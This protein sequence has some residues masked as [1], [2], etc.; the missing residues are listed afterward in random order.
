MDAIKPLPQVSSFSAS[1]FSFLDDRFRD[2][3]DLSQSPALVSELETEIFELD[4][5]LAGLNRQLES[6]LASYASFSD[7]I[8]GLL[9]GVN[10]KLA[11]L[12]SSRSASDGGKGEEETREHVA[13]EEL[14]SLAKEVAQV[15]SVRAYAETALKLDTLVGDI[16]DAVMSSLN[17]NLPTSRSSG[18]EEVRLHAIKTLQ[19]TEEIL[20]LVAKRHPRWGRLVSAVD[21]RVDRALAMLRPQAIADYRALLTS[22][23]WP[24]QLSNLTSSSLDSKSDD[25]QNPLFNMEGNLKSQYCGNFH[26]LCSLQGLQL[27]RKSR[28]LGSHKGEN[29]LFHQPLWAIEEL[30]NPLTVASQR[31][32][33]KW[34]EK[35][36]FIFALVYKITRDYV[37]SMD[38]LL[39][40]LV[41]KAKLAGYSCREEWVSAMVSSLSLYLV[42]EIFPTYVGQLNEP[43]LSSEAKVSWLHLIDLMIS[44]DKRAQ[45]LVSQSG[46]LSL[47][48]D[49][50]LLR[51][52]SLSVFCDRPDW[53]DIWAEIELDERL[54]KLKA[55][56]DNDRNWTVKV[57]DELISTSNVYRPPIVSSILLQHLSSIIERSKSVPAIYLRASFLRLAASSTIQKFLDCLLLRC[58]EA[59]GLTALTENN[60]LIKVSNSINAGHYIESVLDEWCEDVFFLEM[61]SGQDN[62]QEAPGQENFTEPSEGIFGEEFEKLEK[63]RL[64]WIN[65]LSVVVFRGLDARTREYIKNRK[66]WQEKRDK[67]WTVSRALVGALD[68]LQGK[69]SIIQENLNKADFTAMW[70][71]LASEIDKLF[72]N[73]ILMANVKFSDDG[74]ERFRED[75]EVLYGVF[76]GWCVR[77]EGFFPKL[78][79]GLTL[80][81]MKEKQ[82]KEGLSR[83]EKWLRE[84]GVRYMTEAEAKRIAKSRVFS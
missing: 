68:Y 36:E 40:P 78:S 64:E 14:P 13:G 50:N 1:V 9:I 39:Q 20:S 10:A 41:D 58:Q 17:K 60:D 7:R 12:S 54:V 32:F 73:S 65:K 46:I 33:A 26:A 18:F 52:S 47:Q 8:G 79:E 4:Q 5:R 77:P 25:I 21:H 3:A 83:G 49:G 84:N 31:H 82:V 38:E 74:V 23:G 42:K 61:G 80:L 43:D 56:M 55:E 19:K 37:D 28:Q 57:Q 44:F 24:P 51:I 72:F 29:V 16:E 69:T 22:L 59:E 62:P 27:Q 48:E 35:P 81:K 34:S 30:V 76:R 70:R 45:S 11:D 75:M 53:L 67:E 66:Q 6:G 15:E 2:A 63:F 71:S